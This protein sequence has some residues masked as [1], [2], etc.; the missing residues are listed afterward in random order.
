MKATLFVLAALVL[1]SAPARASVP[2]PRFSTTEPTIVASWNNVGAPAGGTCFTGTPTYD[3]TVRDVSNAPIAGS[4]V[5]VLFNAGSGIHPYSD[6]GPGVTVNCVDHSFNLVTDAQ[7]RVSFVPHFGGNGEPFTT[8]T[9]YADGVVLTGLRVRS[10]DYDADG[11]VDVADWTT[12]V[13]DYLDTQ[14]YHARSDFDQCATS[15]LPDFVFFVS[16]YLASGAGSPHP[17]CP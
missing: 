3:V 8:G 5:K 11:D 12:F 9:V 2:D 6:P 1:A 10:P 17:Y 16:Q 4:H 13:G 15:N 7:G 14:N